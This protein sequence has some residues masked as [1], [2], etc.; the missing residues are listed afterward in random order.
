MSALITLARFRSRSQPSHSYRVQ[1]DERGAVRCDCRGF[2]YRGRCVHVDACELVFGDRNDC[3]GERDERLL[4]LIQ[5]LDLE[6]LTWRDAH[7]LEREPAVAC[8]GCRASRRVFGLDVCATCWSR[9]KELALLR[10]GGRKRRT[11]STPSKARKRSP[12]PTR[13]MT[14]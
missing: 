14:K 6:P 1:R 13:M 3:E 2:A 4:D 9:A 10:P 7:R 5:Q 12:G 8:K 11:A